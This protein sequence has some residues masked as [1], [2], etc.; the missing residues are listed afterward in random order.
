[1]T[2][3]ERMLD[4]AQGR[5]EDGYIPAAFFLHFD[6]KFHQGQAAVDRHLEFF[7][8]TDMDFVKIQ[9]EHPF[10]RLQI[11]RPRDWASIP[12]LDAEY[13]AEPL[14]VVDGIVRAVNREAVVDRKSV[15]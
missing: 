5:S 7:R 9:Y 8:A 12:S 1:V 14:K 10:P 13:F 11:T 3:R 2:K 6:P 15:V 4:L